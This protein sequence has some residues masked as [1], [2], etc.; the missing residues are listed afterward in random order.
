MEVVLYK[1]PKQQ[2]LD[3]HIIYKMKWDSSSKWKKDQVT[4]QH[5]YLNTATSHEWEHSAK[6]RP[7]AIFLTHF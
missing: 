5:I 4:D 1:D 3:F 2:V 6:L 7:G